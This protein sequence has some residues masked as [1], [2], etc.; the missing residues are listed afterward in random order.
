MKLIDITMPYRN[1][2]AH[3]PGDMP[4]TYKQ[5]TD[6]KSGS[7]VNVGA[8]SLGVHGGTHIDAPFH[9]MANGVTI[10]KM[11]IESFILPVAVVDAKN[12]AVLDESL[13]KDMDFDR[14]KGVLF[15][16]CT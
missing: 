2:G 14:I 7:S 13:F 12:S 1:E 4:Y 3:W 9:Y 10:D 5:L 11:P 8:V 16:T 15:K 6:I